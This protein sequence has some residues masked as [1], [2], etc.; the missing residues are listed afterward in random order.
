MPIFLHDIRLMLASLGHLEALC[1]VMRG[2]VGRGED[3]TSEEVSSK[4]EHNTAITS[5]Q[6]RSTKHDSMVAEK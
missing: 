4:E 3:R 1:A 2:G 5:A 6:A